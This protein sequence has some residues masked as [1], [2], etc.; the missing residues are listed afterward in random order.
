MAKKLYGA[1][2]VPMCAYC[3]K[4]E[5]STDKKNVL[6]TKKGIVDASYSCRRFKYD[7]LKRQPQRPRT[8]SK[9][10]EVDFSLDVE[11]ENENE[12]ENNML[13]DVIEVDFSLDIDDEE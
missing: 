9:F 13:F 12:N 4:G 2:I 3:A 10:D 11:T 5:M 8:I 6:C 1:N 7:P